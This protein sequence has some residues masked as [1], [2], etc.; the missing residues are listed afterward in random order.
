MRRCANSRVLE[1]GT[2]DASESS[3]GSPD[4][5]YLVIAL[6]RDEGIDEDQGP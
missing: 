6:R 2:R 3:G 5:L 1:V 4:A